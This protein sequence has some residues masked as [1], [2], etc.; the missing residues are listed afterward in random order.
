MPDQR[1]LHDQLLDAA[2][3]C[4]RQGLYDAEDHI[5]KTLTT[6]AS[7]VP[8]PVECNDPWC[9]ITAP[10]RPHH[11]PRNASTVRSSEDR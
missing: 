7:V 5:R 10:H 2:D 9:Y 1:S 3:W 11:R 4:R 8:Q 6:R